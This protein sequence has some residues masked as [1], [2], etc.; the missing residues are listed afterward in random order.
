MEKLLPIFKD[1]LRRKVKIHIITRD[2]A[3][4][5]EF[6]RDQ[7]TNEI[8]QLYELGIK[9]TLLKGNF[10][11]KLAIIDTT[12]IWEGSLNILSQANSKEIMRRIVSRM[13][14][15]EMLKFIR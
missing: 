11:R 1:L 4:H 14:V 15:K 3:E 2:P 6:Y 5:D 10:H 13:M 8:L 9:F 12:I 7:A